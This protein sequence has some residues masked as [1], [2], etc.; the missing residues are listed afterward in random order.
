MSFR[1]NNNDGSKRAF[2]SEHVNNIDA[3]H[4]VN[5]IL[6]TVTE[7][8][9]RQGQDFTKAINIF[10]N[11][12]LALFVVVRINRIRK[13]YKKKKLQNEREGNRRIKAVTTKLK[14]IKK[15]RNQVNR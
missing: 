14:E 15:Q 9:P 8:R 12:N 3:F 6:Y 7:A 2:K 5:P 11:E 10:C 13:R 4:N 1:E